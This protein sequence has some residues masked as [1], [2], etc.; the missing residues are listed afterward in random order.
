MYVMLAHGGCAWAHTLTHTST[1]CNQQ[2]DLPYQRQHAACVT[3]HL[4]LS[5]AKKRSTEIKHTPHEMYLDQPSY[6]LSR[7]THYA[8]K[9]V[10]TLPSGRWQPCNKSQHAWASEQHFQYHAMHSP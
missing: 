7:T 4:I 6:S 1:C 8:S 10:F 9:A 3:M 5:P 2:R